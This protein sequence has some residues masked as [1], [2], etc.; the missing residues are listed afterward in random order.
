[1]APHHFVQSRLAHTR[2]PLLRYRAYEIIG[3]SLTMVSVQNVP[4][5]VREL[6]EMPSGGKQKL[7]TYQ[8]LGFFL[9]PMPGERILLLSPLESMPSR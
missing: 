7:L 6:D 2:I 3:R 9:V 1:M 8:F 4:G 5:H